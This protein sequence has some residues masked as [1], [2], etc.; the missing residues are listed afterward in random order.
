MVVMVAVALVEVKMKRK[1][2]TM[3]L[4]M[5][6]MLLLMIKMLLI[7]TPSK[8]RVGA[9]GMVVGGEGEGGR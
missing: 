8:P 9:C 1:V 7:L 3:L 4:L 5:I 6:K 2:V